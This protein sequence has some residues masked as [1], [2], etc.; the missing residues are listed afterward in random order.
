MAMI[1]KG[2]ALTTA[3]KT[4]G[5]TFYRDRYGKTTATSTYYIDQ[6]IEGTFLTAPPAAPISGVGFESMTLQRENLEVT[7]A[8]VVYIG[9]V[10]TIGTT[11]IY[12]YEVGIS[13]STEPI[14]T[15]PLFFGMAGYPNP[16]AT[17]KSRHLGTLNADGTG[18]TMSGIWIAGDTGAIVE[19]ARFVGWTPN[20]TD[21][22]YFLGTSSYLQPATTWTETIVTKT[23]PI[24][25][26]QSVG[27]IDGSVPGSNKPVL[28]SSATWL[29]ES[30]SQVSQGSGEA[31]TTRRTWRMSG[32][33]GWNTYIYTKP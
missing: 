19:G 3:L 29:L 21:G 27:F 32:R 33:K 5:T 7:K 23:K 1:K 22:K 15:H 20:T 6:S 4:G 13:A 26:N 28:E 14:E 25:L 9:A 17:A 8:T 11:A 10:F 12:T 16:T 30:F 24:G 2:N 18:G 31:W